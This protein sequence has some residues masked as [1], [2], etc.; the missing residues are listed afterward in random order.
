MLVPPR[1]KKI[2]FRM[3]DVDYTVSR[4]GIDLYNNH[5]HLSSLSFTK[6]FATLMTMVLLLI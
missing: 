6:I 4:S 1:K 3:N 2:S 5:L